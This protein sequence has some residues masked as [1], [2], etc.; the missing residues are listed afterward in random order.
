MQCHLLLQLLRAKT[1][2]WNI[3]ADFV[4]T[5]NC[6]YGYPCNFSGFPTDGFYQ[7]LIL[8]HIRFGSYANTKLDGLDFISAL[9]WPMAIHEVN[10]TYCFVVDYK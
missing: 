6:D 9:L 10:G 7:T 1:P 8:Y 4:E 5:C 3:K 2:N